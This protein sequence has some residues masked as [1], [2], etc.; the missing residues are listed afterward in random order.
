[1]RSPGSYIAGAS[2]HV[3]PSR[4]EAWSQSAVL[5]LGLG[6][7]VVGTAV[8][9]L[10]ETLGEGRGVLVQPEKPEELAHAIDE[11]LRGRGFPTRNSGADTPSNSP[12]SGSPRITPT[13]TG[14]SRYAERPT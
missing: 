7:P 14:G 13:S 3:V 1:M 12:T 5:G 8:E 6:V 4:E 10:P 11:L 2:V 9:G